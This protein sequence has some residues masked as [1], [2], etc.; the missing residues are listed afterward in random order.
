MPS[1][2]FAYFI[3]LAEGNNVA[4]AESKLFCVKY[5]NIRTNE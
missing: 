1:S 5:T 2:I 4:Q 3:V